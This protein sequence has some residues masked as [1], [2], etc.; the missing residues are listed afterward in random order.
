MI[1]K[2][3]IALTCIF[4]RA[5]PF[6]VYVKA[7]SIETV[8]RIEERG[9]SDYTSVGVPS[10]GN[11]GY[12]VSETPDEV[13]ALMAQ[14]TSAGPDIEMARLLHAVWRPDMDRI[15][16]LRLASVAEFLAMP[17]AAVTAVWQRAERL[18]KEST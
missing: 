2:D 5:R 13:F 9:T 7:S 18:A 1:P 11:G 17:P 3:F 16:E 10:H 12:K 15:G 4:D 8:A 6:T 14:A